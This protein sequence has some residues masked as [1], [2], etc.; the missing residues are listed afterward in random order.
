M[1]RNRVRRKKRLEK[2][3]SLITFFSPKSPIS[4]QYRTIRTNIQFASIDTDARVITITS[5]SPGEGKSTTAANLA[6]AL[7]QQDYKVLLI[8][9]DLRKPSCHYYFNIDNHLG[10]TNVLLNRN[11]L[12][13]V[14]RETIIPNL[15]LLT[16]GTIPPNP[17][18]IL[19]VKRMNSLMNEVR[20][21]YDYVIIDSPPVLV[22]TDAQLLAQKSD[23]VI[24]VVS[25][26]HTIRE[27]AK[28]AKERLTHA[29]GKILGVILN[30]YN[31]KINK[32]DH[33]YY[34]DY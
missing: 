18:E 31:R 29:R 12:S 19:G 30:R 7:A 13:E 4:E 3:R 24:L 8:D 16:C 14:V 17:S 20:G 23:G 28:K 6:I 22:V 10:L 34:G 26:G 2:E 33:L 1:G 27:N 32:K 15:S 11:N 9:A 5:A 21:F 25:S